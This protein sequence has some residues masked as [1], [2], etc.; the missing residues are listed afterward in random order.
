MELKEEL[1]AL[2]LAIIRFQS[3]LYGIER[4]QHQQQLQDQLVSIAPLWN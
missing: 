2:R 3:H 1:D 4:R